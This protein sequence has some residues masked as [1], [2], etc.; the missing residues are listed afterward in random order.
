MRVAI[1][2]NPISGAGRATVAAEGVLAAVAAA[3]HEGA[4]TATEA[5]EDMVWLERALAGCDVAVVVGGDGAVRLVGPLAARAGAAI[6]HFPCG[7]ENLFAREFGMT[8]SADQLVAALERNRCCEVDMGTANGRPF[9]LMASV[10]FDAEVVHDLAARRRGAISHLSY[11]GPMLR[12]VRS[13]RPAVL[14]VEVDGRAVVSDE[15]GCVIVANSRQYASR[16]NP[17]GEAKMDDGLLDVVWLP[18]R[19]V[20]DVLDWAARLRLG[21]AHAEGRLGLWRGREVVITAETAQRYQVDG[22]VG[23]AARRLEVGVLRGCLRVL[24]P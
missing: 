10:G 21:R 12:L 14:R 13:W 18:M 1:I 2:Y 23:G 3:G 16:L 5:G 15:R 19:N 11:V 9:L 22:D 17:A 4:L 20:G 24:I 6:Y 8:R 7:T